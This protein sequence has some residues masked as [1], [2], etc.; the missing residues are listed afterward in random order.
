M[1]ESQMYRQNSTDKSNESNHG[2]IHVGKTTRLADAPWVAQR[3]PNDGVTSETRGTNSGSGKPLPDALRGKMEQAFQSDFSAV[4]V[5]EGL[6]ATEIGALAFTQGT[7]IFFAPGRYQPETQGGQELLGHELAHVVQQSE[8]RV[9]ATMQTKGVAINDNSSL[10]HEADVQGARA[11]SGELAVAGRN[12]PS[13]AVAQATCATCDGAGAVVAPADSTVGTESKTTDGG[14]ATCGGTGTVQAKRS[15]G[16][17]SPPGTCHPGIYARLQ[18]AVESAKSVVEQLGGC[19]GTDSC[20][21]IAVKIAALATE[22]AARVRAIRPASRA[23]IWD[24]A[25]K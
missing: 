22:I 16:P 10:E 15:P 19:R 8:G 13:H 12:L 21:L 24:I 18:Q 5:F 25:S 6:E 3:K 9:Q 11:A 23:A 4:R 17:M 14:C 1:Y 20:E 2:E 7:N